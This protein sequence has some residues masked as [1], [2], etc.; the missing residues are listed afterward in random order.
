MWIDTHCHLEEQAYLLEDGTDGR[1]FV[2]KRAVDAGVSQMILIGTGEGLGDAQQAIVWAEKY[3]FLFAAIGV[4]PHDAQQFGSPDEKST[5]ELL[6]EKICSSPLYKE[7]QALAL[8]KKVVAI[9]EIGLDYYYQHSTPDIQKAV[10]RAF[11]RMAAQKELPVSLHIREAHK[12]ALACI[13]QEAIAVKGV[14]HCFTGTKEEALL[15]LEQGFVLSFSGIVTFKGSS[16][17]REVCKVVPLDK[18]VLETDAPYLS[19]VPFRGKTNEPAFLLQTAQVVAQEKGV[20]MEELA[21]ATTSTARK[22]FRI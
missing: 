17:L 20:S 18:I 6:V 16:S 11:L 13:R 15:W 8:S 7:M 3:P 10:F 19:P 22:L 9:G 21:Q 12:D 4:H 1:P 14:V 5:E 2:L